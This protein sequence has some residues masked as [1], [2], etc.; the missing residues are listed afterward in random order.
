MSLASVRNAWVSK[1][2]NSETLLAYTDKIFTYPILLN[3]GKEAQKTYFNTQIKFVTFLVN[4][5]SKFGL[6]NRIDLTYPVE[7]STY[8]ENEPS[9]NNYNLGLDIM[10][11]IETLIQT[12]LGARWNNS[13]DYYLPEDNANLVQQILIDEKPVWQFTKTYTGYKI[14]S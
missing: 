10:E 8:I 11:T 6:N 2:A 7:V 14:S 3:S 1:V 4:V 5:S 12:E 9:G 13:V